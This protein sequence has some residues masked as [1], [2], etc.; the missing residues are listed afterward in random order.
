MKLK[1]FLQSHFL[2]TSDTGKKL[3]IDPGYLTFRSGKFKV[4]DFQGA[5]VYLITHQ[6]S[7]HLDP[8]TIKEVVGD[9]E[10]FGNPDVVNK[11]KE[12]GIIHAKETK[13]LEKFETAGFEITPVDLPHFETPTKPPPNTGFIINGIFFHGGDG[14]ILNEGTKIDVENAAL[15]AGHPALS[16]LGVFKLARSLNAK[17][18]IPIHLDI[19]P[20]D[21]NELEKINENY[22]FKLKVEVIEVGEELEL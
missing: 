20:R 14:Y 7:D 4:Q 6:H 13:H 15:A 22:G 17:T 1:K 2:I 8:A 9:N 21:I 5:D 16:L 11:L 19:Y 18:F 3:I 12:A 10:V